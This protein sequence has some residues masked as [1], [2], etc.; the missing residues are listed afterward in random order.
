MSD[1]PL[2][3]YF[4]QPSIYIRLPSNGEYYPPGS[5]QKTPN[6]EYPVLPMTTIDEIT[7]RTPDA[8]FNGNAVAQVIASCVPNIV[9][10]WKMPSMDIDTI[11]VAIRIATYGHEMEIGTKCPKCEHEAEYGLDL[12][13][14]MERIKAPDYSKSLLSG[15]LELFFKPMS[16]KQMN[17]NNLIQFEEQKIIE[18]MENQDTDSDTKMKQMGE[19]LKKITGIT[20]KALAQNIASIKTPQANVTDPN[21]IIEWLANCDRSLFAKVRDH[22]INTKR[23]GELPPLTINCQQCQ[24][25][26]EQVF[27]LDM[28]SFFEAAS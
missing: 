28:S 16:Y 11:L 20:I 10:P 24:H 3:Q 8:L 15:D 23:A 2:S 7:Y 21:H 4:R 26:F 19:V 25:E 6:N 22:I 18:A 17:D 9:D 27:T 13:V 14:I 1:N 5:L 12:R